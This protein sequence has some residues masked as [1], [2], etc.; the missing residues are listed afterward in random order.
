MWLWRQRCQKLGVPVR[1][2]ENSKKEQVRQAAS[3]GRQKVSL[4]PSLPRLQ[5][6]HPLPTPLL[7][8]E[9][10]VRV[11][12]SVSDPSLSLTFP[13]WEARAETW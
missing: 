11:P 6:E 7:A 1:K 8:L 13:I 10:W 4:E 3:P 5:N 12:F 9:S 2:I